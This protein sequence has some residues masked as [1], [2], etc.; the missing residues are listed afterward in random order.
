M[1][2]PGKKSMAE[3][4]AIL[5][6]QVADPKRGLPDDVFYYVSRITPLVNVD[7]LV[8]DGRGRTLLSWR[9]DPYAGKG[10]HVPG[11]IIRFKETFAER[12]DKV[13]AHEIGA[14]VE[15]DPAPLAVNEILNPLRDVRGHFI[16]ILY[17]CRLTEGFE[18][19]N[20]GRSRRDAGFLEWHESCP[21]DLLSFQ[22][23][24]SRFI[25]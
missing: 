3:A 1:P 14:A 24:Y 18:P 21:D 23:I 6:R 8:Q 15:C 19:Q 11:G 2:E 10:W 22:K 13:A 5:E 16:S 17:R 12:V 25:G 7:L 9:D 20:Q 4:I